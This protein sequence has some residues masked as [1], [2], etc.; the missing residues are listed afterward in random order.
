MGKRNVINICEYLFV[1][2]K[3]LHLFIFFRKSLS[4]KIQKMHYIAIKKLKISILY[5]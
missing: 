4:K 1:L 3:P 5:N 2:V